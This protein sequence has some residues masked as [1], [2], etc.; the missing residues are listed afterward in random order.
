MYEILSKQRLRAAR[1]CRLHANR[2]R[3]GNKKIDYLEDQKE[4]RRDKAL[5]AKPFDWHDIVTRS[6]AMAISSQQKPITF[7]SHLR[8]NNAQEY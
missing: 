7:I 3:I 4:R 1:L 5:A 8:N 6:K 2:L